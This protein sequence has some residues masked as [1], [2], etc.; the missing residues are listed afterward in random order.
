M[1][2]R[3]IKVHS[4]LYGS[5]IPKLGAPECAEKFLSA[6]WAESTAPVKSLL[7]SVASSR[8]KPETGVLQTAGSL[9]EVPTRLVP[10]YSSF[11]FVRLLS[12]QLR[13]LGSFSRFQRRAPLCS[14]LTA[15]I[16]KRSCFK[17][18]RA[19]VT[20]PEFPYSADLAQSRTPGTGAAPPDGLITHGVFI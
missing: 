16:K 2:I 1:N 13:S 12:L 18:T 19:H 5:C 17:E 14:A 20:S 3:V 8:N 7:V 15:L 4:C 10:L 11:Y 9:S 6:G